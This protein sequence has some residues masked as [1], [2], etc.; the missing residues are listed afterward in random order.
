M[1]ISK[2]GIT[3]E[4]GIHAIT[5]G[6]L[7]CSL[8]ATFLMLL[9]GVS[10]V[11]GR[12][13][14]QRPITGSSELIEIGMLLLVFLAVGYTTLERSHVRVTILLFR[15]SERTQ[16]IWNSLTSFLSLVIVAMMVWKL[17]ERSWNL[18]LHP[19]PMTETLKIPLFPLVLVAVIGCLTMSLELL[20][21]LSHDLMGVLGKDRIVN[22]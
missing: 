9:L 1:R 14:F 2:L 15:L 22:K 21:T 18:L 5:R 12:Y 17:G 10:T 3:T 4:K 19:G 16:A 11:V 8:F 6:V 7:W 20:V 13:F